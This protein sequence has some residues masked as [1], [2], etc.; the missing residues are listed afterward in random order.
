MYLFATTDHTLAGYSA[1]DKSYTQ[2]P[3]KGDVLKTSGTRT[4]AGGNNQESTFLYGGKN[5]KDGYET[6][7]F[8]KT[9]EKNKVLPQKNP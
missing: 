4:V 1:S 3:Q 5:P 7:F 8:L 2:R 9:E 6:R